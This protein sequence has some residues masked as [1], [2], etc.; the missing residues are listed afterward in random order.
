MSPFTDPESI[1][2]SSRRPPLPDPRLNTPFSV[3]EAVVPES[4][5]HPSPGIVGLHELRAAVAPES[6]VTKYCVVGLTFSVSLVDAAIVAVNL[7]TVST[8]VLVPP[9]QL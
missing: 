1:C 4:Y 8:A 7:L 9:F 6:S 2:Q 3:I 5:Q